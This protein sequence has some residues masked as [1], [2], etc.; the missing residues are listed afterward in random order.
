MS[1]EL[2][3]YFDN[4]TLYLRSL[5]LLTVN[6]F[7][8]DVSVRQANFNWML[9][10]LNHFNANRN[11]SVCKC[12]IARIVK[13]YAECKQWRFVGWITD[14]VLERHFFPYHSECRSFM[15]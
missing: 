11:G 6:N 4:T 5:E 9:F 14:T 1:F 2:K 15:R 3:R 12:Y 7:V 13:C 10:V 8:D